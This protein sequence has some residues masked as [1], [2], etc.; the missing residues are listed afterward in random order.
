M[1][2]LIILAQ[3]DMAQGLVSAIEHVLGKVPPGLDIQPIDYHRPQDEPGGRAR[4][5][6]PSPR[7][8]RRGADHGRCLRLLAHQRRLPAAGPGAGGTGER[9]ECADAA[10]GAELP[11]ADHGR[12]AATR[13]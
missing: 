11:H 8:G 9:C 5:T 1:I 7:P 2:S 13:P 12:A 10:A 3:Q 6:H 4:R